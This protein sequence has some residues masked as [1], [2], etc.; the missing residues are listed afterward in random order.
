M[1]NS[2]GAS[3]GADTQIGLNYS[4]TAALSIFTVWN[5]EYLRAEKSPA[6]YSGKIVGIMPDPG[7]RVEDTISGYVSKCL[8]RAFLSKNAGLRS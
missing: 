8:D 6:Q 4:P 7:L 2:Q 3:R 1:T 5:H